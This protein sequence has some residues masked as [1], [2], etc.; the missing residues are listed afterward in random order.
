MSTLE[1]TRRY[2]FF[3]PSY[4]YKVTDAMSGWIGEVA[5]NEDDTRTW[6]ASN[7]TWSGGGDLAMTFRTRRDAALALRYIADGTDPAVFGGYVTPADETVK[8]R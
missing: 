2:S 4:T 7:R 6:W 5:R 1:F 3:A 8:G